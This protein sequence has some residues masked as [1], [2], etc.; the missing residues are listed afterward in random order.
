MS[1]TDFMYHTSTDAAPDLLSETLSSLHTQTVDNIGF[2][3]ISN[4]KSAPKTVR[5]SMKVK[6]LERKVKKLG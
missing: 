6:E 4:I 1:S 2:K 3:D 5:E